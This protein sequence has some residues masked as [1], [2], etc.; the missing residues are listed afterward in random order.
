MSENHAV[1]KITRDYT[2]LDNTH[3]FKVNDFLTVEV[4]AWKGLLAA[5]GD[6][7]SAHVVLSY[8]QGKEERKRIEPRFHADTLEEAKSYALNA[9][10]TYIERNQALWA[11]AAYDLEK[12]SI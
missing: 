6:N 2:G 1:W 8:G 9:A 5:E 4:V 3:Q 12:A 11:E 10:K 7:F